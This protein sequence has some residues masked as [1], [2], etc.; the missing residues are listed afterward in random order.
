[1][2]IVI[3]LSILVR[4]ELKAAFNLNQSLQAKL[5]NPMASAKT[6]YVGLPMCCI[7]A[8]DW[9]EFTTDRRRR[10]IIGP[11]WASSIPDVQDFPNILRSE[12]GITSSNQAKDSVRILSRRILFCL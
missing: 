12:G 7:D 11:F 9:L 10:E 3:K 5:R 6:N 4:N 2:D 1:M 8:F